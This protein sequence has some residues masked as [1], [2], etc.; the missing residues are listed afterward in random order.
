MRVPDR[1]SEFLDIVASE[2]GLETRLPGGVKL[3][4][5]SLGVDHHPLTFPDDSLADGIPTE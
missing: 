4:L 1:R 3:G 5:D 2:L